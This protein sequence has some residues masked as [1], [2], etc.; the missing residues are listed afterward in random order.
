ILGMFHGDGSCGQYGKRATWAINKSNVTTIEKYMHLLNKTFTAVQFKILDVRKTSSV[1]KLVACSV[2]QQKGVIEDFVN[3]FRTMSY[4]DNGEKMVHPSILSAHVDIQRSYL[5]GLYDSDGTKDQVDLEITQK[6]KRSSLGISTLLYMVGY[7][8][9]VIGDRSDK[10]GIYRLRARMDNIRKDPYVI[11]SIVPVEHTGYVYDLTTENHHFQAGIGNM[12]VHNTD[13]IFI[14]MPGISV[15][16]AIHYGQQLDKRVQE[17]I[18]SKREPMQMEYEKTYSP[19]IITRR[20]G[21]CGAKYEKNDIDFKVAAMGFQIVRR[22]AA[23]LCTKTMKTYFDYIFKVRDKEK[24]AD[25]IKIMMTELYGEFLELDDFVITKKIAKADYKTVPPHVVAWRRMVDRV[26]K[27]EA[28]AIGER[29]EFVVTK[30]NKKLKIDMKDAII[31]LPLA[32]EMENKGKIIQVDKDYYFE[33]FIYNPMVKI[34]ELIHGPKVTKQILNPKAYERKES[35][36][37]AKGNLL[38]FFGKDKMVTKKR[39]RGLGF[40]EK[41]LDEVK[42]KRQKKAEEEGWELMDDD[43]ETEKLI[44]IAELTE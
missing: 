39:Y 7:K 30:M 18:F 36:S 20:K 17:D 26:G 43:D 25:S 13:S 38:G 29:F 41:F 2:D 34:M 23:Q 14:K 35:V 28:P 19:F 6:G 33:T 22:D 16:K 27:T 15:I 24:A 12:V 5:E 37:A 21:Y 3:W 42:A 1:Y 32:K 10:P 8:H 4:Y 31:D 44:G 11:K 9:V 40:D